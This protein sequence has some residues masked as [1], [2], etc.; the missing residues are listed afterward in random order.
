MPSLS[1]LSLNVQPAP[2]P[3]GQRILSFISFLSILLL[4]SASYAQITFSGDIST[5]FGVSFAENVPVRS[6][7]T[8][9]LTAEGEVG[10]GFFPDA[11]FQAKVRNQYDSAS[12]LY[13]VELRETFAHL[14]LDDVDFIVGYDTIS[15]GSTDGINPVD[16]INP[17]DLR[18]SLAGEKMPVGLA[19]VI[20]THE[21]TKVDAVLVPSHRTSRLPSI[22]LPNIPASQFPQGIVIKGQEPLDN[23]LPEMK[24]ENVQFGVRITQQFDWLDGADASFS[25]Y[26]GIATRPNFSVTLKP[27]AGGAPN[28]FTVQP[29]LNYTPFHMLGV[30]FSVAALGT[31][32]RGEAAYT[33]TADAD[34]SDAAVANHSFQAVFGSEYIF[35]QGP[36]AG[37]Q[38]LIS[39]NAAD[40]DKKVV[41]G[42]GT[43]GVGSL[44]TLRYEIDNRNNIDAAWLHNYENGS[45]ALSP[46]YT[47]TFADGVTGE[48]AANVVYGRESSPL[49]MLKD[50]Y[51]GLSLTLNYSF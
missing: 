32:F 49:G 18:Y 44:L 42:D 9:D 43:W 40:K 1:M 20:Y 28:E 14:Y 47:Y 29:L 31:V 36:T 11:S 26:R 4:C 34:G 12:N 41:W 8:F 13:S 23:Q 5:T 27:V 38:M 24:L 2:Q 39:Y 37:L 21:D 50:I 19:R 48:L 10:Q 51:S 7:T 17:R 35:K 16:V 33:I 22:A 45:G 30:D 3:K 46:S 25:Y 15:W 6:L